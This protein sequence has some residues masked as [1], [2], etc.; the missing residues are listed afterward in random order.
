MRVSQLEQVPN[1]AQENRQANMQ[2]NVQENIPR[3]LGRMSRAL[4]WLLALELV[5]VGLIAWWCFPHLAAWSQSIPPMLLALLSVLV[6]VAALLLL[7]FTITINNFFLAASVASPCPQKLTVGQWCRLLFAEFR[8]TLYS[9]SW[10]MLRCSFARHHVGDSAMPPVL[11]VH[12]YV[13]NSGYWHRFS[14]ALQRERINH[15]ALDLEP[16]FGSID[17]YVPLLR[18][19]IESICRD[20]G[21]ERVIIVAHSMGGLAARAYLR[22]HGSERVAHVI[23]IGSPHHGTAIA[24][25]GPGQ[26]SRQMEWS[27]SGAS[28]WLQALEASESA[29]TR[30]LITSIFSY[31]DNI[32][33]PQLSSV[34]EGANNLPFFGIGHVELALHPAIHACVLQEIRRVA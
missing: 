29:A 24:E 28:P 1:Q 26:N 18:Q 27:K 19:T 5:I 9:S 3:S 32:V 33:S 7:R 34:L 17:D 8:A 11:L 6:G 14:Q 31:Q 25:R 10:A 12:G 16:V 4:H 23:T 20:T 2:A 13:C 15:F 22:E 21:S 30:S